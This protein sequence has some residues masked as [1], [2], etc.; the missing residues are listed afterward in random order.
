[1]RT[2]A[3]YASNACS[4]CNMS[5]RPHA[6]RC[7][8]LLTVVRLTE[9]KAFRD[10]EHGQYTEI[11]DEKAVLDLTTYC[12]RAPCLSYGIGRRLALSPISSTKISEDVR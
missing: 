11:K 12:P 2:T 4:S 3:V 6:S 1:M 7:V 8:R 10:K 5:N 9:I